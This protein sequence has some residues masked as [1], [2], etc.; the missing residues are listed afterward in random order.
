MYRAI[1]T[2]E[3]MPNG[4][5]IEISGDDLGEEIPCPDCSEDVTR[6]Y[7]LIGLEDKIGKK[8]AE[9]FLSFLESRKAIIVIRID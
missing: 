9:C 1:N 4:Y 3:I 6:L 2:G 7:T 5:E 8:C